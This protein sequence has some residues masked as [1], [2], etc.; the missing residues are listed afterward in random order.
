MEIKYRFFQQP[1]G[2]FFL[3]GPRGTGKSTWLRRHFEG[4]LFAD[5]LNPET[6]RL[7]AARPERLREWVAGNPAAKTVIIDEI[8]KVPELLDVVHQLIEEQK[9]KSF[10]LTGSS[11]RKLRRAGVDLLAGRAVLKT[12]H[13]FMA[14][15]LGKGFD[16]DQALQR[17]LLPL[18]VDSR[19][20]RETLGAYAALYLREEVQMEGLV[21]NLGQ[22]SRF[23]EAISFSHGGVLNVAAVAREC[24]MERKTAEGYVGVLEDL[25][26]CFRLP[27][28]SR[29]AKRHLVV[30]PKFYLFDAGVFRSLRPAGPL[31]APEEIAGSALE[32]VVAQHLRAW[33]AYSGDRHQLAFWRTKSGTEVDFVVYGPEGFWAL[34]VKNSRSVRPRDLTGLRAFKEDYPEAQTCLLY[35]GEERLKVEHVLC[36]PCTAFLKGLEP[37]KPV[38]P[39]DAR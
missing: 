22:F 32:G 21:R 27:V 38:L 6:Y 14:A 2:S 33:N 24:Q 39:P 30:H 9:G 34:E 17:G 26:L 20:P 23:L 25:L 11:A 7:Y 18:V 12:L 37:G 16:L 3:F 1:R 31:D 29:R 19:S 4:A 36:L 5:L 15:E 13:P 35:R 28:F 10:V 8:Q